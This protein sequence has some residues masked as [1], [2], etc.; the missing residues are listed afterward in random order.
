MNNKYFT[1][2]NRKNINR[3][4][5]NQIIE[6][7][8]K[9]KTDRRVNTSIDEL[10]LSFDNEIIEINQ[11]PLLKYIGIDSA[12]TTQKFIGLITAN[13]YELARNSI[14]SMLILPEDIRKGLYKRILKPGPL[15]TIETHSDINWNEVGNYN[16]PRILVKV[17]KEELWISNPVLRSDQASSKGNQFIEDTKKELNIVLEKSLKRAR[18]NK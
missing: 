5:R 9:R 16:F 4:V 15:K 17:G 13:Q 6:G 8:D 2:G 18:L 14:N 12:V 3:R 10:A 11:T 1:S 7:S